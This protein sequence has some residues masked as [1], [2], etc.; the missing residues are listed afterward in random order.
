MKSSDGGAS[1][2]QTQAILQ[3]STIGIT[4]DTLSDGTTTVI[5]RTNTVNINVLNGNTLS[6]VSELAMFNGANAA[7]IG[8]HGR[9]EIIKFQTA[10]LESDGTFTLSN[11]IRGYRGTEHNTANHTSSDQFVLLST[12][13]IRTAANDAEIDIVRHYKGVTLG[14]NIETASAVAFTNTSQ[15]LKPYAPT[16]ILGSIDGSNNWNLTWKRRTRVGGEWRDYVDATLGEATE[17]YEVVIMDGATPKRTL[18]SSTESVQYTSAQ[19]VTDFGS[20]QTTIEVNIY[21]ISATVARGQVANKTLV[22]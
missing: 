12:S 14:K 5:D 20:N 8:A 4:T 9:W 3:E 17:S 2:V 13:M 22:G 18:T 10:N 21:Q 16:H 1:Y 19:Q 7:A 11:L 6:S 15:A